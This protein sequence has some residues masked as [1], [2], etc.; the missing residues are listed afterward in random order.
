MVK[1]T[2]T[3]SGLTLISSGRGRRVY[4]SALVVA[5]QRAFS[6]ATIFASLYAFSAQVPVQ[7]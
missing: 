3:L 4:F 5:T 2:Y 6:P 7:M 1:W